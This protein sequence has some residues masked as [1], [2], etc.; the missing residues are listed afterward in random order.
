MPKSINEL[1]HQP[2]ED[3]FIVVRGGFYRRWLSM[4]NDI[5]E[6]EVIVAKLE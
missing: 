6:L 4:I 5:E 2:G 3:P 1:E